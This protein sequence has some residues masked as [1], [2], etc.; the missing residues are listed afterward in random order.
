MSEE[1]RK[2]QRERRK[3]EGKTSF[4]LRKEKRGC[5]NESWKEKEEDK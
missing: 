4:M 1:E 5:S 2:R 3:E